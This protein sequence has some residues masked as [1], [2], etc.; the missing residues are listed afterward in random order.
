M[1]SVINGRMTKKL[2]QK[3]TRSLLAYSILILLVSAPAF[4]YVTDWLYITEIS[5]TLTLQK[6]EFLKYELPGFKSSEIPSFN[7]Y[8]R[9]VKILP[10]IPIEKDTLYNTTYYD[11][12]EKEDEPYRELLAPIEIEGKHYTFKART[13]L[14]EKI[15]L[16]LGVA[17]LFLVVI[18]LL[19][20]GIL[21]LN[22]WISKRIWKPF[23]RTLDGIESFE[24]DKN[25]KPDLPETDIDEFHRLNRSLN[26]LIEK[27]V[28]IYRA[29][30]EFVE[31]AAHELQTPLALFQGKIDV[32]QQT[33]LDKEQSRLLSALNDDVGRLNRLNK[34]L[35]LLSRIDN[36]NYIGKQDFRAGDYLEKNLGFFTEQALSKNISIQSEIHPVTISSNSTLAEIAINNLILNA[37]RHNQKGGQILVS[38]SSDSFTVSNSGAATLDKERLFQRFYKSDSSSKGNGLG[39]AIISK[40]ADLNGWDVSYDFS[41]GRHVFK[42]R[43]L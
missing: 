30:R 31:N 25:Q 18:V 22:R 14:V 34:N 16:I 35:L 28:T 19:L 26:N 6:E 11:V 27:N 33:T 5:E 1:A 20:G 36:E 12:L 23:Y 17:A 15:D 7:K 38:L 10:G 13:N 29:Q 2:L 39:L 37:I 40:I 9:N 41:E 8:N 42:I 3:T 24:L 32:L 4:Y 43:F 21:L